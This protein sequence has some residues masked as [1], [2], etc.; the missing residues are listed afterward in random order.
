[1]IIRQLNTLLALGLC[2]ALSNSALAQEQNAGKGECI[3][4][5]SA[6]RDAGHFEKRMATLHTNLKLTATQESAWHD[7]AAKIKPA[8]MAHHEHQDWTKLSTPDQLDRMVE[9]MK[10]HETQMAE[11]ATAIRTFYETLKPEQKKTFDEHFQ[12]NL[13]PDH[14]EMHGKE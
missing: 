3:H 12:K 10:A 6:Q 9:H 1:M 8:D 14:H 2:A 13:R 11:H 7:F 4:S 5:A